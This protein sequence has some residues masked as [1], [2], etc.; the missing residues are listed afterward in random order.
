[1]WGE[2]SWL[3]RDK[4]WST[5]R[6]MRCTFMPL[7][8]TLVHTDTSTYVWF[9]QAPIHETNTQVFHV[10]VTG[11]WTGQAN[12]CACSQHIL[13]GWAFYISSVSTINW[14]TNSE[15][16]K[17]S[18][19]RLVYSYKFTLELVLAEMVSIATTVEICWWT[20][21]TVNVHRVSMLETMRSYQACMACHLCHE[22]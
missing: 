7:Q 3:Q 5:E 12:K 13:M 2:R 19:G 22:Y 21:D 20:V 10:N 17:S 18:N 8:V 11:K 16:F 9:M 1:M 6:S 4:W 14:D 15:A